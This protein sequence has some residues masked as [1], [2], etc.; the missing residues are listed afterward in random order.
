MTSRPASSISPAETLDAPSASAAA[1]PMAIMQSVMPRESTFVPS[2]HMVRRKSSRAL[3]ASRSAR[4]V[5]C[6]KAL[7][8][9]RPWIE[10]RNSA[11]KS[12]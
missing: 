7:S 5:L 10:S 12:A 2:T 8:V 11:A 6:P 3:S 4:A 9:P 1:A